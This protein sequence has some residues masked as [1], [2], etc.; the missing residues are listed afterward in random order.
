V[1]S[2]RELEGFAWQSQPD[3]AAAA[4]GYDYARRPR[5]QDR[6]ALWEETGSFYACR[7]SLLVR[8]GLRMGGR[9]MPLATD[10]DEALQ[11]DRPDDLDRAARLL[12]NRPEYLLHTVLPL[13]AKVRLR[14]LD[15]DGVMTDNRV[16]VNQEGVESVACSRGDGMG[17]GMLKKAG[18]GV[19]VISKEQNPVVAARCAKLRITCF[20]GVDDK[21]PVLKRLA[22]EQSIGAGGV[23]YAGNDVNDLECMGWAGLPIAVADAEPAALRAAKY[24]T[25]RPGG[26]GAVREICDRLIAAQEMRQS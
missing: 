22:E 24:V 23:A 20:H 10:P 17:I 2:A 26:L 14:A 15:F 6:S 11:I 16:F 8:T 13:F 7:A 25:A 3:G 12:A 21:L 1:F 19:C 18:V 5:R 9:I 4:L